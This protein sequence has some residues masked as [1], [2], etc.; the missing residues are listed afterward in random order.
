MYLRRGLRY[1]SSAR[2]RLAPSRLRQRHPTDPSP[3]QSAHRF[4]QPAAGWRFSR[5][6]GTTPKNEQ[7]LG[8]CPSLAKPRATRFGC[9]SRMTQGVFIGDAS[10]DT[11]CCS[12]LQPT[13]SG[14]RSN[15]IC[16]TSVGTQYCVVNLADLGIPSRYLLVIKHACKKPGQ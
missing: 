10:L 9:V 14:A 8:P 7:L 5:S 4:R 12:N 16:N 3:H 13:A 1:R 6:T 2:S 15:A 11:S